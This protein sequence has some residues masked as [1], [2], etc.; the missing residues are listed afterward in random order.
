MTMLL[1]ILAH[2][3]RWVFVLFFALLVLGA[4]Q[5][6]ARQAT[7]RRVTVLPLAMVGLSFYGVVSAFA[8]QPL[9][10]LAWAT[11]AAASALLL[12]RRPVPAGTAY[13][14]AA[15]SFS[16][17]GS[18]LPLALMM[19]IFFTKYAVGASLAISPALAEVSGFALAASGLYGVFS[20]L[21]LGRAAR[22]WQLAANAGAGQRAIGAA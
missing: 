8:S 18:A 15:R 1:Q 2:T 21:F 7:L 5:L 16:L 3:P 13:D 10:L 22:L 9:A 14:A 17:P 6:S 20:G 19:G 4:K 11:G 12:L